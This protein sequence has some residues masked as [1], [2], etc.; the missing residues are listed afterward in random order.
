MTFEEVDKLAQGRVWTGKE[1]ME[2]GLVDELGGI[3]E[4][5]KMAAELAEIDEY[6]IRNYPDYESSFK[7]LFKTPF[8]SSAQKILKEELG[9]ENYKI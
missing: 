2:N 9:I 8:S 4:A 3:E 1:A 7:D 5:V 6:R